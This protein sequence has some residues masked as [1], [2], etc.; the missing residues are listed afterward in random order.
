MSREY[1]F[2]III[3][4]VKDNGNVCNVINKDSL[5]ETKEMS[6]IHISTIHSDGNNSTYCSFEPYVSVSWF[7]PRGWHDLTDIAM[8][9]V[10]CVPVQWNKQDSWLLFYKSEALPITRDWHSLAIY[11]GQ[12]VYIWVASSV[13]CVFVFLHVLIVC[14]I[15]VQMTL[16]TAFEAK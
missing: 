13:Y 5:T 1:F 14:P 9:H 2:I 16:I 15:M 10:I 3:S 8:T 12:I 6:E 7:W 4:C 11:G